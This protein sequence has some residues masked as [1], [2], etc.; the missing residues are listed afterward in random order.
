VPVAF[1]FCAEGPNHLGVAAHAT[2]ANV[3]LATSKLQSSVG[4][5]A[6][7]RLRCGLLEEQG[8]NF[9][10]PTNGHNNKH[11]HNKKAR[12]FFNNIVFHGF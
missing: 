5:E 3:N 2:L 7:Y 9:N 6:R 1:G 12:G 4:L 8:D 10:K 11:Q